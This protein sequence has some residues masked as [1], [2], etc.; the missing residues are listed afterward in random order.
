MAFRSPPGSYE[1]IFGGGLLLSLWDGVLAC[2]LRSV[3]GKRSHVNFAV[4][5]GEM[6]HVGLV[7]GG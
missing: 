2:V 4:P 7:E 6:N 5:V 1:V 3:R